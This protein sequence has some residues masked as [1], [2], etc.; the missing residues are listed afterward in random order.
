VAC[1]SG[2]ES[3]CTAVLLPENL[4]YISVDGKVDVDGFER[5]KLHMAGV[6]SIMGP[7]SLT[8]SSAE[9]P[10]TTFTRKR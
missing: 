2:R 1:H 10:R 5:A 3:G 6:Q 7:G 9:K 4:R 8:S